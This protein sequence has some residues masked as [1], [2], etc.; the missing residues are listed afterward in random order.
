MRRII[1]AAAALMMVL[2]FS[3]TKLEAGARPTPLLPPVAAHSSG[4]WIPW[5]LM[6]CPASVILSALVADFR[7]HRQLTNWEAWTCGLLYWF[8]MPTPPKH[9]PHG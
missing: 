5:T 2:A 1:I 8:P 9:A 7:D 4:L 6:G 3:P